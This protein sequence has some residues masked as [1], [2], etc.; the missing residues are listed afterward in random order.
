MRVC[1]ARFAILRRSLELDLMGP[2]GRL[3]AVTAHHSPVSSHQ[4]ELRFRMVET[5]YVDPRPCVMACLAAQGGSIGAPL[6]HAFLEFALVRIGV[7]R[8][9]GAVLEVEGQNLVRPSAKAGLVAFRAGDRHMGPCENEAC[10]LMFCERKRGAVKVFYRVAILAAILIRRGS[11]LLVVGVLVTIGADDEF[12]FVDGVFAGR[13]VALLA[14]DGRVLSLQRIVRGGV[15]F[16]A[17]LRRLPAVHGVALR[18][19]PLAGPGLKLALMRIGS[20]AIRAP[21]ELQRLLEISFG[22]AITATHLQMHPQQRVL[23]FRMVELRRHVDLLPAACRV[24]GFA[25]SFEGSLMRVGVTVDAGIELDP[26]KLYGLFGAR[27]EVALFAGHLRVHPRQGIFRFGMIELLGLLP[28]RDIVA[29]LAIRAEL[30]FMDIPVA[31]DAV[32]R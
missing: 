7:A 32:F 3:M 24:T 19:L 5:L 17:K 8:G 28:V 6:R 12:H 21:G 13:C 25:G 15:F 30:A 29:A 18:A 27:G 16:H 4:R 23:C 9:T 1:M 14:R 2:G 20:M 11:E 22:M 26:R 10:V 31:G